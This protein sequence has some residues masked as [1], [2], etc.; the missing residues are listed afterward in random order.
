MYAG[1]PGDTGPG[2]K[3]EV[4]QAD[5]TAVN[6]GQQW[7]FQVTVQGTT[8]KSY[9]IVGMEWF[10]IFKHTVNGAT[11]YGWRY[12]AE[13]DVYPTCQPVGCPAGRGHEPAPASA[14]DSARGV[15]TDAGD[16]PGYQL[17]RHDQ[18][19]VADPRKPLSG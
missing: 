9:V 5:F 15:R 7:R 17:Q 11:A 13:A 4:F 14:R 18:R 1:Q 19:P 16:Q 3:I 8:W 10:D 12:I 6:P 2:H